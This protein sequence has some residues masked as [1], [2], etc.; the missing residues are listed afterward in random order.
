MNVIKK[1]DLST[2]S[3]GKFQAKGL[4]DIEYFDANEEVKKAKIFKITARHDK[5]FCRIPEA[6]IEFIIEFSKCEVRIPAASIRENGIPKLKTLTLLPGILELKEGDKGNLLLPVDEGA[7]CNT[8]G[9]QPGEY[10]M[11]LFQTNEEHYHA[12]MGVCG[13]LD[14]NYSLGAFLDNGRFDCSLRI[15]VCHGK[16]KLYSIDMIYSL[17]DYYDDSILADDI[18]V[19]FEYI[20]SGDYTDLAYA[21]RKYVT[22]KRNILSLTE[23]VVDNPVL[24]YAA[25]AITM[26]CRLGVKPMPCTVWEQTAENQPPVRVMM[27]FPDVTRL[28]EACSEKEVGPIE[29]QMV[30]WNYG[31]HDGAF[32][33][34]FPVESAFG[35]EEEMRKTIQRAGEL[36]Y[37]ISVHDCYTG[38][39]SLAENF[40]IN[41][42]LRNHGGA[43]NVSNQFAGGQC[44]RWCPKCA[45]EHYAKTNMAEISKLNLTG[46]YYVDVISIIRLVKCYHPEHPLS[47]REAAQYW[48]KLL[49]LQQKLFGASYSE[50]A[51]EWALPELDHAYI[52]GEAIE[53]ECHF[54]DEK[55]PFFQIVYHASVLYSSFRDGIDTFPGDIVYLRNIAYGGLPQ[56]YYHHIFA[57]GW[58]G[59]W[60]ND[61]TF[62]TDRLDK[63]AQVFKRM[64]DDI[65]RYS[66][67]QFEKMEKFTMHGNA[68][69]ETIYANGTKVWVNYSK[70]IKKS[71]DGYEIPALDFIV[72]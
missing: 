54:V 66:H 37:P 3:L 28:I 50:G 72:V 48:K 59:G 13:I 15:R 2:L 41:Y 11:P 10:V 18:S 64:S 27:R 51:R 38:G 4:V 65:S 61:L 47:R 26:R 5:F 34:V 56:V 22:T 70:D 44:Y 23:K 9:K 68:L 42:V 8:S 40:N 1:W 29:F 67:L 25:K 21:Y 63:D 71:L 53:S 32:P 6:D 36:G 52:V 17:R 16:D 30:G 19:H 69:S 46:S 49:K 35:G 60:K 58:G 39:Y 55:V 43:L 20:S 14:Q 62:E 57:V 33:Q 7:L 31:G 45:Y 12:N 24:Q